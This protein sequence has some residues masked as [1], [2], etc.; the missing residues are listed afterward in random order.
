M[1]DTL[2][3]TYVFRILSM[4]SQVLRKFY[5]KRTVKRIPPLSVPHTY[6]GLIY[7]TGYTRSERCHIMN[8][9]VGGLVY[10]YD[11]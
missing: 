1:D 6:I 5:R 11:N 9:F 4:F 2:V 8:Y 10:Q 7:Y 3:T